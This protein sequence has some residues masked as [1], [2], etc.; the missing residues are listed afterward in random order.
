MRGIVQ[1]CPLSGFLFALI[2]DPALHLLQTIVIEPSGSKLF[3]CADDLA[4]VCTSLTI[5]DQLTG[6][7]FMLER[8]VLLQLNPSKMA[9]IP[10]NVALN[11]KRIADIK[12]YILRRTPW[13]AMPILDAAK[14][15]GFMVGPSAHL[16]SW[17]SVID[18]WF[19]TAM[20]IAGAGLT[21]GMAVFGYNCKAFSRLSYLLQ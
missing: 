2:L 17:P 6:V 8:A 10:V 5:L 4:A 12:H 3:G 16:Q 1:G 15:L 9:F 18:A 19:D 11:D 7:F 21:P 14:Y 20:V 13:A